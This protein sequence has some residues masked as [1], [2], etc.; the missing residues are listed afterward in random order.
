MCC[1]DCSPL[2]SPAHILR[3]AGVAWRRAAGAEPVPLPLP[4]ACS[5]K[6][7]KLQPLG[8]RLLPSEPSM[9]NSNHELVTS[10]PHPR[11]ACRLR[12]AQANC[13]RS[14]GVAAMGIHC[15]GSIVLPISSCSCC[16]LTV[17]PPMGCR[18][19]LCCRRR[20]GQSSSR[21]LASCSAAALAQSAANIHDRWAY[22]VS[23]CV[24]ASSSPVSPLSGCIL[25]MFR[26]D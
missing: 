7:G 9:R 13:S 24:L 17:W 2:V 3:R 11:L 18:R 4:H 14:I 22:L 21:G 25:P 15:S 6:H 20:F 26:Q 8:D 23:A 16:A 12:T 10:P 19:L 5:H 1:C